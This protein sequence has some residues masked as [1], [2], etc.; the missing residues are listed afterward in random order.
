[1]TTAKQ[2]SAN[3][4]NAQK[5]TGPRTRAGKNRSR[6]NA[7]VHGLSAE[8]VI[9]FF[10]SVDEYENLERLLLS[11]YRPKTTTAHL[12]VAR[13]VSVLWR[14]NRATAIET[15]LF[16]AQGLVI[17]RSRSLQRAA[18]IYRDTPSLVPEVA[19]EPAS[20]DP[21]K[22]EDQ[23]VERDKPHRPSKDRARLAEV[24][25][26]LSDQYDGLP[27]KVSRYEATLWRQAAQT[28]ALLADRNV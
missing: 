9:S 3:R 20:A 12:L 2:I 15:G 25:L 4:Q 7:L 6:R 27:N 8:T 18:D 21:N 10:E 16:E 14:L 28:M 11:E 23:E 17:K 24:F 22:N 26:R 1:M 5:S 13:L 19:S